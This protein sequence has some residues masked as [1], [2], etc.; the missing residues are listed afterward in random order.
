MPDA[1]YLQKRKEEQEMMLRTSFWRDFI[2]EIQ[3]LR[4]NAVDRCV[5]NENINRVQFHQ[6]TVFSVDRILEIPK[7]LWKEGTPEK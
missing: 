6:G 5:K 7:K 1:G 3:Q 4:E 2:K